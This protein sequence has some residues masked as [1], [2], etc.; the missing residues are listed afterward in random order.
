MPQL[1]GHDRGDALGQGAGNESRTQTWF[2]PH[3]PIMHNPGIDMP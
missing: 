3:V 2:P 1:E